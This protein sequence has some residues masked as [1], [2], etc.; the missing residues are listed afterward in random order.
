[1]ESPEQL[2]AWGA[3]SHLADAVLL[4]GVVRKTVGA[5]TPTVFALLRHLEQVGFAGAPRVVGDGYSFV[6][7][8]SP[9]PHAW[10]DEAV[11]AV[12]T[13]LRSPHDATATFTPPA[14]AV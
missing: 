3:G 13:L 2:G 7:G 10:S 14:E 4:D 5:W 8:E 6:P 1:M 11:G 12:G 9:H